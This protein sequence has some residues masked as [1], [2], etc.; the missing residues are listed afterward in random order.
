MIKRPWEALTSLIAGI[1][2]VFLVLVILRELTVCHKF[3]KEGWAYPSHCED[4]AHR[5]QELNRKLHGI[6]RF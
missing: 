3:T 2:F 5:A 4:D 6:F 1:L